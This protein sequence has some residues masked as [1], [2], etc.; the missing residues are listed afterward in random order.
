MEASFSIQRST[1]L[2]LHV[3]LSGF[4]TSR[5]LF[6]RFRFFS[7]SISSTLMKFGHFAK[8]LNTLVE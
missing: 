3:S 6:P 2:K 1:L 8:W 5:E 7:V 4:Q